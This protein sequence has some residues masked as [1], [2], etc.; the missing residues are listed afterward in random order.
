MYLHE[1][2]LLASCLEI[3]SALCLF[4]FSVQEEA[5]KKSLLISRKDKKDMGFEV[6]LKK[7]PVLDS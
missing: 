6:K 7:D 2:D 1:A 5:Y 3:C 4:F